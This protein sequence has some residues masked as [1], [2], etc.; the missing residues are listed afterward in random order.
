MRRLLP[1]TLLL[2]AVHLVPAPAAHGQPAAVPLEYHV[3]AAYLFNFTRFV[4]WPPDE[5][6]AAALTICVAAT[7]PFGAALADTVRGEQVNGRPLQARLVRDPGGCHVLFIPRN[8]PHGP[9][10]QAA[11]GL[12]VLTVGESREF[13]PGGGIVNFMIED[14][15]VRF[16]INQDAAA[17]ANLKISSRLLRLARIRAPGTGTREWRVE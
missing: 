6:A 17:R 3:K 7:N 5:D 12:P 11:R 2:S 16:E 9:Y 14:G 15:R 1:L 10:L 4:E 8:V 13:L